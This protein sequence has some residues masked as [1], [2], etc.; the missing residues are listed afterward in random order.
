MGG[1]RNLLRGNY[2]PTP[3]RRKYPNVQYTKVDGIRTLVCTQCLRTLNKAPR[4]KKTAAAV[5]A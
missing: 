5:A 2:N 4:N 3:L 1:H